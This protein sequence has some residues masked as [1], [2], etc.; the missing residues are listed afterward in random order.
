MSAKDTNSQ[1][2]DQAD[3]SRSSGLLPYESFQ[4]ENGLTVV[5]HVDRS[6][7]VVA[8]NL[9][10][11]VGS[12]R[13]VPGRTGFAHMFEHLLF[14]E[15]ENLGKGGLDRLS[16][17]IGG[18][19]ANGSTSRDRTN[20][21]QTVPNNALEKM[22]WA[23]ADKLG[24]FI[25]TVTDPV[26]A[27]EKQVVKNEKRQGVDNR[28]Y[29]HLFSVLRSNLYPSDHPYHWEVIGSLEDLQAATL[30]DVKTFYRNWYTPNNVTLVVAGDFDT[31]QARAWVE[32]YFAEIPR[33]PE[34]APLEPRSATLDTVKSFY[35]E[36]NFAEQPLLAMIWPAVPE[37]HPDSYPLAILAA[38]L[39]D[40]KSAPLN[41]VLI[42]EQ[43]LTAGVAAF[44]PTNE[45][46]GEFLLS[47][48]AFE[49]I[50]LDR[51]AAAIKAGFARF[52]ENGISEDALG[53]AKI[54][55]EV[56]F[57][58]GLQSVLGKSASL[59][60][61]SIFAGDPGFVDQDLANIQAVTAQDVMR[62]YRQYI[63]DRPFVA[64][65]FVPKG[66]PDLALAGA[67][68]ADV[69]EEQVV[70]GAEEEFDA[71][72]AA[73]YEPTPS[74]FD[75]SI[76][77]PA[78]ASPVLATPDIWETQLANGL[79]VLGIEDK[80]IP[81]VE[82]TLSID[83]GHLLDTPEKNGVANLLGEMMT[84]G[85]A[86]RTP[87]ELEEA[88]AA[89]GAEI[90]VVASDEAMLLRGETL[91][92]NFVPVM[93]LVTEILLEPRWDENEFALAKALTDSRILAQQTDPTQLADLAARYVTY[94]A[95]DIRSR[96]ALG[97]RTSLASLGLDDL[98]A[99][100]AANLDPQI[101]SFRIVGDV[102]QADVLAALAPL[103]DA[104]PRGTAQRPAAQRP[105]VPDRA[106]IYFYD[107][108]GAKQ[109]VFMFTHPAMLRTDDDYYPAT[110]ANYRLGGGGFA[111]RLTQ[112]L[113]EGKG[114]TY[115]IF[116]AFNS[117]AREG[118]FDLFS[119][120][121]SNVTLE[122]TELV[123]DIL[124]DYAGTF[125]TE[126]L[127]VTKS[128]FIN[129][130]AR[131]FESFR[132]KLGI[133]ADVDLYDLPYD[134]VARENEIVE[135]ITVDEI[136]QL[137]QTYILPE[138]MNYVIVGDAET[139]LGR[140]SVLGLGEPVVLNEAVDRLIR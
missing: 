122:A 116:S 67:V 11:H 32:R 24:W 132:A 93:Q 97:S 39:S 101:A 124:L 135:A 94:G 27:K 71:S 7:P 74:T 78:G 103:A 33:G 137:A 8:V 23:E 112:E 22:L 125:T 81:L 82:F 16:A 113:R 15:S 134:Y 96:S 92:R 58:S 80:E 109:S 56:A 3:L 10:A 31:A 114:Y 110:V 28:P 77:P 47:V 25:N 68:K 90:E 35:H 72:I 98:K 21:L 64:A 126:D 140:L 61:Y 37:Y 54:E 40:G 83:G 9:T 29:G 13:E 88:I 20:Y 51:V 70:V 136:R 46:A 121:R 43:K 41:Q 76:E 55:Q 63:K 44:T 107:L 118:R 48:T 73:T 123:R 106:G 84:R 42:D 12:A 19:G 120:V 18:S 17:R 91:A 69:V 104:W 95:D 131:Q 87:A 86:K 52:E 117:T 36:D 5:F 60:Q 6:D 26:L 119:Q 129:S 139:Q 62:V 38:L 57:Y 66:S 99:F 75:R 79:T 111:S 50:D 65:S 128:F 115:G 45:L 133:L 30:E 130:K 14:L 105:A 1:V 108:P 49:D 34:I 4:L 85:T 2:E 100:Y 89:L 102:P 59:A 127:A 53:R 138:R